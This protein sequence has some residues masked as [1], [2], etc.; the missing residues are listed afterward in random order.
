[1]KKHLYVLSAVALPIVLIACSSPPL[2][3]PSVSTPSVP[4]PSIAPLTVLNGRVEGQERWTADGTATVQLMDARLRDI[5]SASAPVAADGT[6]NMTPPDAAA[7]APLLQGLPIDPTDPWCKGTLTMTP[8]AGLLEVDAAGLFH[9]GYFMGV[10]K[11]SRTNPTIH[12]TDGSVIYGTTARHWMYADQA[13]RI[14]GADICGPASVSRTFQMDLNLQKGWNAIEFTYITKQSLDSQ[15]T[16]TL[17]YTNSTNAELVWFDNAWL[18]LA[19]APATMTGA[20]D[21]KNS[22][23]NGF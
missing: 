6:F 17:T 20:R 21:L 11:T 8:V 1:M 3:S 12:D 5:A 19:T 9:A 23:P 22:V 15:H 14:S 7:V 4:V 2:P 18:P 16:E 13:T 10:L